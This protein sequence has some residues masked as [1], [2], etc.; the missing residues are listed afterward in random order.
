MPPIVNEPD[1]REELTP[2]DLTDL[3]Y[4][5]SEDEAMLMV[6]RCEECPLVDS[7]TVLIAT[8]SQM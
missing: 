1:D 8:I 5:S 3:V 7:T 2:L 6:T 4:S